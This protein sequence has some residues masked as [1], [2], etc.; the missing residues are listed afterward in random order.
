MASIAPQVYIPSRKALR[1]W[2]QQHHASHG[3]I[4]LVYD[5]ATKSAPCKLTYDDIVEEALC[6]GWIDSVAGRVSDT[7]SKLYL[8]PRKRR[9]VWSALFKKRIASLQARGLMT[10]AGQAKIDGAITDG[11]W[12]T[13]DS[14]E[15]LEVPADLASAFASNEQAKANFDAF[16][17]GARKLALTWI[18]TAKR[19]ETRAA[20]IA[21]TVT[22]AARN[23][24]AS[25]QSKTKQPTRRS[26]GNPS[27]AAKSKSTNR[28]TR[29]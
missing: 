20:R 1:D 4:W 19:A 11:T 18:V 5:K 23:I 26:T 28:R 24:R 16:P 27:A 8:S 22:L 2:L 21:E 7:Q 17:P 9:S 10:P 6:F 25:A 29:K 12:T 13:L 15:A 3:S 14:A